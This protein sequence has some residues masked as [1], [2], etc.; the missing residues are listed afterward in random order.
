MII[1]TRR[2]KGFANVLRGRVVAVEALEGDAVPLRCRGQKIETGE[3][4]EFRVLLDVAE[5]QLIA[6]S[7]RSDEAA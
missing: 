1:Q 5:F 3:A 7:W 4:Y 2:G 6:R